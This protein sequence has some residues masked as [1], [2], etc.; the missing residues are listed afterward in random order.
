MGVKKL[1]SKREDIAEEGTWTRVAN[2]HSSLFTT[3]EITDLR[4]SLDSWSQI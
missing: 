1:L 3:N 2:L 4:C